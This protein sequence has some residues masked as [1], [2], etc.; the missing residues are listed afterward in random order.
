MLSCD[1]KAVGGNPKYVHPGVKYPYFF[2]KT[3]TKGGFKNIC[4]GAA[5]FPIF[6]RTNLRPPFDSPEESYTPL[7]KL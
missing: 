6:A 2:T 1:W 7:R 4:W 3:D 5:G